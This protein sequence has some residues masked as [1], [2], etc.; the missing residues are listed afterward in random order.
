M[1]GPAPHGARPSSSDAG[2]C[3]VVVVDDHELFRHGITSMLSDRGVRVIASAGTAEELLE[4]LD[5]L[6]PPPDVILMDLGLPGMSG[7]EAISR[8]EQTHPQIPVV[9]LSVFAE[10]NDLMSAIL[11]GASGY[12]LKSAS[13]DE[14]LASLHAAAEGAA[15]VAPELAGKL[16]GRIRRSRRDAPDPVSSLSE[17]EREVLDL[18]SEGC[19]NAEIAARLFISQNTVKNHVAAILEKLNADN[20]VQAVVRAVRNRIP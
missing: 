1:D 11:A 14:V 9:V 6:S 16:L 18:M 2:G 3:R 19:N 4:V 5:Q 17:R 10:E 15:V 20:R 8:L 7:V 12:V 13:I